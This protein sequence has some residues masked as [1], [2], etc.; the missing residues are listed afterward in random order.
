MGTDAELQNLYQS[1][2]KGKELGPERKRKE[3]ILQMLL[4][5]LESMLGTENSVHLH[6]NPF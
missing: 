2:K 5:I 1:K 3:Q 6:K 4:Y